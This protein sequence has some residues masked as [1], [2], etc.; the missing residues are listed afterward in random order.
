MAVKK[1]L[2]D[3]SPLRLGYCGLWEYAYQFG[4]TLISLNDPSEFDITFL[5]PSNHP[6]QNNARI[7]IIP[8]SLINRHVRFMV[9][10]HDLYHAISYPSPFM[11]G[12][13]YKGKCVGTIHDL[14]FLYEKSDNKA[15]R[16][17]RHYQK[18]LYRVDHLV[19]ISRYVQGDAE[20]HLK[21]VMQNSLIY[22]GIAFKQNIEPQKPLG[23]ELTDAPYLFTVS[24][25]MRKKNL[26]SI[27]QM[28]LHLDGYKLVIAGKV[29]HAGYFEE[30]KQLVR[31]F[32]LDRRVLFAGEI[33][34]D[35]KAWLYANCEA[36]LFPS[37]AEGFGIPPIEAMSYSKPVF[38][39]DKTSLPEICGKFAF[40]WKNFESEY[41]ANVFKEGMT[42]FLD[43]HAYP[44]HLREHATH[45]S[46]KSNV[47]QHLE[48]YRKLLLT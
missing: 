24:T 6:F 8:L 11:P 4:N 19:F 31:K 43:N 9:P 13:K 23:L 5:A 48:L 16:Y 38:V 40:Y 47:L 25:F 12:K 10:C 7:K 20:R 26:H 41:M 44:Q 30:V 29:I 28:M 1:L 32:N 2:I 36:F 15:Q 46:W 17:L 42:Y 35:E 33:T 27:V 39:S 18:E 3:L 37:L 14:N 21:Y 34:E 45:Y 22:N